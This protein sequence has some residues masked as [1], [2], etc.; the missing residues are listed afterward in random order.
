MARAE[1]VRGSL[2]GDREGVGQDTTG[3][4]KNFAYSKSGLANFFVQG[5]MANIVGF[6][7]YA[8]SVATIY[9]CCCRP[10]TTIDTV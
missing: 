4:C 1:K 6:E 2:V 9:L 5:H 8:V 7:S 10:Q 3:R